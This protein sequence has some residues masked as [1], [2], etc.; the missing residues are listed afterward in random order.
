MS[1][2]EPSEIKKLTALIETLRGVNGCPWDKKQTPRSIVLYLIEEVFELAEAIESGNSD[3]IL[4][5]L[6]DVLFQVLFI[7]A[8]FDEKA[9]FNL[10]EVIRTNITKM[11]RRHPHV[12]GNSSARTVD[13]IKKQW[14]AIKRAEK[15]PQSDASVLDS[16]PDGLPALMRA[17]RISERAADAGF[18]WDDIKGVMQKAEEEWR[19]FQAES[20][21]GKQT[22]ARRERALLEF[23]DL[24]FTLVNVARFAKIH[25]E[26]ALRAATQ[27]FERR[28]KKM[29]KTLLKKDSN[30]DSLSR[31]E[32]DHLW[33]DVK[34]RVNKDTPKH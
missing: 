14:D 10:N 11:I 26:T 33:E 2:N 6:G 17:S 34:K 32:I 20:G 9:H 19:E 4:E 1:Q 27:K 3:A 12:F 30:L 22:P 31:D 15:G 28:F 24:M 25:P 21:D 16:V 7:A 29:E 8:L 18:D 13:A 23:G 5:E